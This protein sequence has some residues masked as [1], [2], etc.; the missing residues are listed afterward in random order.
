MVDNANFYLIGTF[1]PLVARA[2]Y[3]TLG[4][5]QY[6][7]EVATS[8]AERRA[9]GAGA[10][11]RRGRARRAAQRLPVLPRGQA[12]HR[13]RPPVDRRHPP[14]GHARVPEGDRLRLPRAG[15]RLPWSAWSP[16][17]ATRTRSPRATSAASWPPSSD[18]RGRHRQHAVSA[19]PPRREVGRRAGLAVRR[20]GG[21]PPARGQLRRPR[22]LLHA[23][24]G[25][26]DAA[27][28]LAAVGRRLPRRGTSRSRARGGRSC[29]CTSPR[30]CRARARARARRGGP[31]RSAA[32]ASRWSTARPAPAGS[33][34]WWSRR[35]GRRRTAPRSMAVVEA[36]RSTH[37]R[38]DIWF[39]LDTLEYLRRGGRIGAGAGARRLGAADQ[40]I[41]TFGTEIAPVGRVRTRKRAFE[42]MVS[43]PRSCATVARPTG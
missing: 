11:R 35:R 28:H 3:P 25:V 43:Y 14:G 21:R 7:G 6:P 33:A 2:T 26:P 29:R 19:A 10:A 27:G 42:R 16:R 5:P 24:G 17:S 30:D 36:I 20:L 40:P 37:E 23:L 39:C 4:F 12:V 22:R 32:R 18:G 34:A 8:E 15:R 38:L 9:E 31:C 1:Y 13:R 41:L